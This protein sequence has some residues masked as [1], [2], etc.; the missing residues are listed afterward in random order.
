[1]PNHKSAIK[2][3]RQA[4]KRNQRNRYWRSTMRT[5]IK[6]VRTAVEEDNHAEATALLRDA[7]SMIAHVASKGVIHKKTA[8]RKISRLAKLVNKISPYAKEAAATAEAE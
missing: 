2:R 7:E 8:S 5:S 3:L 6:K 4:E 1:M